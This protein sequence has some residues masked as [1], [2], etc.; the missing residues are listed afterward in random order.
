[1][2][3]IINYLENAQIPE[4]IRKLIILTPTGVTIN[5]GDLKTFVNLCADYPD[6]SVLQGMVLRIN[7]ILENEA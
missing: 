3:I 4:H 5:D 2:H 1:M 6:N 7:N